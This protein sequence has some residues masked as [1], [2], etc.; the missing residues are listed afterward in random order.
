LN[1][2]TAFKQG[3]I[4]MASRTP[5]QMQ[6]MGMNLTE[7]EVLTSEQPWLPAEVQLMRGT[8][9]HAINVSLTF[10]NLPARALPAQYVAAVIAYVVKPI[11]WL[12]ASTI[13]PE[14]FDAMD[15]VSV[16]ESF[17]PKP[18]RYEQMIALVMSYGGGKDYEPPHQIIRDPVDP[19]R[20]DA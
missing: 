14:T 19:E 9:A 17:T 4:W 10:A 13:A 12:T 2:H 8:L 20:L 18:V 11:N 15:A 3:A 16:D 5:K 1:H 6:E 7:Y